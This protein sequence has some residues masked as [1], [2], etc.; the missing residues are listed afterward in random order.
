MNFSLI[1]ICTFIYK[2]QPSNHAM[3]KISDL[4]LQA[5]PNTKDIKG[6]PE[7]LYVSMG[8]PKALCVSIFR[9]KRK[10]LVC[11]LKKLKFIFYW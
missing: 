4:H 1:S 10:R 11:L 8:H 3:Y 2:K 6:H 5:F 9:L 7:A